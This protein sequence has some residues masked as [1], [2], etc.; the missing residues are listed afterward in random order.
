[1]KRFSMVLMIVFFTSTSF[2]VIYECEND[3][4]E[5]EL[6]VTATYYETVAADKF[7][8]RWLKAVEINSEGEVLFKQTW[9]PG[10]TFNSPKVI[11]KDVVVA[12]FSGGAEVTYEGVL[13][14]LDCQ[15]KAD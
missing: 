7:T 5:G 13:Y 1:M 15:P 11:D 8:L 12:P 2:A 4:Q 9:W 14:R 3:V 10:K 6:Q